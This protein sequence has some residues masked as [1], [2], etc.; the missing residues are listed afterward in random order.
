MMDVLTRRLW[1]SLLLLFAVYYCFPGTSPCLA[2]LLKDI[3]VGEYD[4][5]TRVVF[6]FDTPETINNPIMDQ[7]EA[8]IQIAFAQAQPEFVRRIQL[9]G[10]TRVKDIQVITDQTGLSAVILLSEPYSRTDSFNLNA[11]V[12]KVLDI[13][14]E[15]NSAPAVLPIEPPA[16]S[17]PL[18]GNLPGWYWMGRLPVRKT[19]SRHQH[20]QVPCSPHL[21][22]PPPMLKHWPGRYPRIYRCCKIRSRS[23]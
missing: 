16:P 10:A 17:S 22:H 3:R 7:G 11:P 13:Y 5:F 19:K 8:R 6:E 1:L 20:P 4:T 23:I 14:W 18:E 9:P 2:A 12:R 21:K 15:N